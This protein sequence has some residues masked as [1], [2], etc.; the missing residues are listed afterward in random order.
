MAPL[1]QIAHYKITGKLGEGGMGTVYRA[2]D[3]KLQ[4][5][6]AVKVLPETLAL[7]GE[8]LARF[9]RE[10]HVLASLNH[11]NISTIYGVEDGAIVMELVEG[12]PL[13]GPLSAEEAIALIT[14]LIDALEYAHD[15]GVVHRDLKPGNIL[16]TVD[17]RLK[18][19]DFGL[20]KALSVERE[21]GTKVS[22]SPTL[23]FEGTSVGLIMGTA[24]YMAP[25]QARGGVIDRR[26]DIWSFGVVLFELMTG[27]RLFEGDNVSDV[28]AAVLR[29]EIDFSVVPER[30]RKLIRLCLKRD[31][32]Q[33]LSH[34]SGARLL[35]DEMPA[36]ITGAISPRRQWLPWAVAGVALSGCAGAWLWP[37]TKE[38]GP[39]V[40]HLELPFPVG[41]RPPNYAA[42]S[43]M[44]VPSPDGRSIAFVSVDVASGKSGLWIRPL[45]ADSARRLETVGSPFLPFWSPDSLFIAYFTEDKLKR[46][47]AANGSVQTIC[48]VAKSA[49]PFQNVNGG[50]WGTDGVIAFAQLSTGLMRVAA[51]GGTPVAL[52]TLE[53][54]E[55]GHSWPQFLPGGRHILYLSRNKAPGMNAIY[56]QE[57]GS[58]KRIRVIENDT[59]ALW[60]PPNHLLFARDGTLFAQHVDPKSFQVQGEPMVVAE[61]LRMNTASGRSAFASSQNGVLAYR[62]GIPNPDRQLGWYDRQGTRLG[63]LGKPGALLTNPVISPDGKSVAVAISGSTNGA[64][65]ANT[66]VIDVGTGVMTRQTMN[67]QDSLAAPPVWS[68]DSQRLAISPDN[69]GILEVLVAS[70]KVT[71][72]LEGPYNYAEGW[73]PDGRALL[74]N[75]RDG[76]RLSLFTPGDGS[77]PKPIWD[78]PHTKFN[79]SFSPDGHYVAYV[80]RETVSDHVKTFVFGQWPGSR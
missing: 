76:T 47:S 64:K 8:R 41:N 44:Y 70:G 40:A 52:T 11:P 48:E 1:S 63:A 28:L 33:R 68:P 7:E 17:G 46:V 57:I 73:T 78:T 26:A 39:G 69:G 20:A 38:P 60:S 45:G 19:L 54:D 27:R 77:K 59:R 75:S 43:P 37:K 36:A 30:F 24:A 9:V 72:L 29:Q 13:E 23:T 12:S 25:E 51:T 62:L 6:V 67:S 53:P 22:D 34:I 79:F 71:E 61:N 55:A 10:A 42:A 65:M 4:R 2:S 35:L 74:A 14:Q 56:A 15:N 18:V 50:T 5:E 31:A 58:A 66:W 3:T 49:V 80:S 16:V 21:T 32:R